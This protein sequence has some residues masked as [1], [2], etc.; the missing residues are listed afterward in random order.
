QRDDFGKKVEEQFATLIAKINDGEYK[1]DDDLNLNPET[2]AIEELTFKRTGIRVGIHKLYKYFFERVVFTGKDAATIPL[3]L[4]V[5]SVY[6]NSHQGDR[7]R[8][9]ILMPQMDFRKKINGKEGTIDEAN[10]RVGGFFSEH[11]NDM[12]LDVRVLAGAGL[13]ASEITGVYL[14]ELGHIF[15]TMA[16]SNRYDRLNQVLANLAM[17]QA[18]GKKLEASYIY[19]EL[20]L[21]KARVDRAKFIEDC[22]K[23]NYIPGSAL[24]KGTIEAVTSQMRNGVYDQTA[25]EQSA[26]S[27]AARFGYG[28]SV[29]TGLDKIYR[30]NLITN[31]SSLHTRNKAA[32][33][34]YNILEMGQMFFNPFE[35]AAKY[36]QKTV[37]EQD[38]WYSHIPFFLYYPVAVYCYFRATATDMKDWTYDDLYFRYKRIRNEVVSSLK[39]TTISKDQIADTIAAIKAI[40]DAMASAQSDHTILSRIANMVFWS[41]WKAMSDIDHQRL[42]E[43]L[44]ANEIFL[45]AAELRS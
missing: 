5:N 42:Q 12:L 20:E 44:A 6:L 41:G 28:R 2:K 39:D 21:D 25:S 37:G 45:K 17:E 13:T 27:F 32:F 4:N 34:L 8:D 36:H 38:Q 43:E 19:K 35:R 3:Y 18:K 11:T 22:A 33:F 16:T 10:A 14:H 9:L 15:T 23:T 26:D 1:N 29:V 30:S 7:M 31:I 40:D 24:Y